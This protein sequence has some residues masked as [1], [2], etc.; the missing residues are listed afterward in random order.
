[1]N[2]NRPLKKAMLLLILILGTA[3]YL[4]WGNNAIETTHYEYSNEAIP[5]S[6]DSYRIV[7]VS[8]LH[9]KDFHGE[10]IDQIKDQDPNLILV[11]GDVID[12]N[13]T[14]L[15][16]AEEFLRQAV[17]LAPVYFVSGNHEVASN[18]YP[19]LEDILG[20]IGVKNLDDETAVIEADGDVLS[21]VGLSDPLTLMAEEIEEVGERDTVLLE[22]LTELYSGQDT[23]FSIL[24][25]HRAELM[26]LYVETESDLVLSGHA[27][28]GQ[29]RL[30]FIEGL[31][32]PSQGFFPEY[33]SGRYEESGTTMI[34]SR[35]LG[36]SLFPLRVF[37]RPELVVIEL[38]AE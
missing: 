1:M 23:E 28:G 18:K 8:D 16:K 2:K 10:L 25:S 29:I 5:A 14:D 6:F 27:H 4:Y 12:S 36:N 17:S 13:R 19:E 7:Q 32:A 9:N 21:L 37:N 31:Y 35:G 11:T 15:A 38:K 22:N 33:T 24:L 30:P 20:K 3:Y 26:D 34:V